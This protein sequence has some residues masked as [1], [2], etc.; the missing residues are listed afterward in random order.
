MIYNKLFE[1]ELTRALKKSEQKK[2]TD[3][4]DRKEGDDEKIDKDLKAK[5]LA[6]TPEPNTPRK[7]APTEMELMAMELGADAELAN[8]ETDNVEQDTKNDGGDAPAPKEGE[9][10]E[11]ECEDGDEECE[12]K[13]KK[14]T[15]EAYKK[16]FSDGLNEFSISEGQKLTITMDRMWYQEGDKV[17]VGIRPSR[18]EPRILFVATL[19]EEHAS[20][21]WSFSLDKKE[22]KRWDKIMGKTWKVASEEDI[23]KRLK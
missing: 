22:Q 11:E 7:K 1:S 15:N 6:K 2:K 20:N 21:S 10:P 8:A 18:F 3:D 23:I 19:V 14:E 16:L 9:E 12:E 4:V 5:E 17:S 13:K